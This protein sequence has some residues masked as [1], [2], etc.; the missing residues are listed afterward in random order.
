[1]GKLSDKGAREETVVLSEPEHC[2]DCGVEIFAGEP[3]KRVTTRNN[4]TYIVHP[5]VSS[6]RAAKKEVRNQ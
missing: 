4:D 1:M 3:A 5:S 6:C 2:E